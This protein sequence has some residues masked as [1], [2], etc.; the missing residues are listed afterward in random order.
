MKP[1]TARLTHTITHLHTIFDS[2]A[3]GKR[4]S[5]CVMRNSQDAQRRIR[6]AG[7]PKK[8]RPTDSAYRDAVGRDVSKKKIGDAVR[9]SK[10]KMQLRPQRARPGPDHDPADPSRRRD[11]RPRYSEIAADNPSRPP[12]PRKPAPKIQIDPSFLACKAPQT[13]PAGPRRPHRPPKPTSAPLPPRLGG[14]SQA[15]GRTGPVCVCGGGT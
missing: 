15:C 4:Y 12:P 6:P 7:R 13:P 8:V 1:C 14:G 9:R 5:F 10:A 3:D 2:Q 11:P